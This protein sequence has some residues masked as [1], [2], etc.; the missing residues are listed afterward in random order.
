MS[1]DYGSISGYGIKIGKFNEHKMFDILYK[2]DDV[3]AYLS[4]ND[5]EMN[6]DNYKEILDR[7]DIGFG[8]TGYLAAFLEV[9]T[10]LKITNQQFSVEE[11]CDTG[12]G[13][14]IYIPALFPEKP[15]KKEEIDDIF[16]KITDMID[17]NEEP[18]CQN[19][20]WFG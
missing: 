18:D 11:D 12:D 2:S 16:H 20:H 7:Y 5:L 10:N 14:L 13:Y 19:V 9:L 15:V 3:Q 4:D 8:W 17:M 1:H 6:I